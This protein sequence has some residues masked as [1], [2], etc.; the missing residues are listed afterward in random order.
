[1]LGV[2]N[3]NQS[4]IL[5][6]KKIPANGFLFGQSDEKHPSES[7][8]SMLIVESAV[9]FKT[10]FFLLDYNRNIFSFDERSNEKAWV[11]F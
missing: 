2:G 4:E 9:M 7:L 5:Y 10:E 8:V 6:K 11:V 1:M 3:S